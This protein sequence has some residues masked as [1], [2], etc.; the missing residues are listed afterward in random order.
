M[1]PRF[2]TAW[3]DSVYASSS[4]VDVVSNY[5]QLQKKGRRHW[6]LCPFH[7]EKTPSFTVN[8][9]MNLYY[10]FGCK[11]SGNIVQFVMEME[12][13]TYQEALVSLAKQ[14]NLPPPPAMEDDP[15][16]DARRNL[17]ERLIEATKEAALYYHD[18]LWLPEN[19]AALTYLH[20][21][22]LDDAVIRR[23]G[24]G[25]SP[26]DW[27]SL[28]NHLQTK[29]FTLEELQ[30]A[31]LVTV[32]ENSRYDTFR[33]RVMFPI[34]NRY[35]QTIG[36]GA[37]AMGSAQPKY[38]N[39]SES[40]IFNK[41]F[42]VYG[43]NQLK[44]LR[45]PQ[46]LILVEGYLDVITLSQAGISNVIAT[47]GTALTTEQVRLVKNYAP[48]VWV[49]YDGDEP[50]QTA[51]LRALDVLHQEGVP[52]CVICFPEGQDPDDFV[53]RNGAEG[54]WA[55]KPVQSMAFRLS[56]LETQHDLGNDDGKREF[57][58]QACQ[59]L[60]IIKE[61]VEIDYYLGRIT[62][63]TGIAKEVLL[64]QMNRDR[65]LKGDVLHES[66]SNRKKPRDS[67]QIDQSEFT[68]V[69]LLATGKLPNK[70]VIANEFEDERLR[71]IVISLLDGKSPVNIMEEA[72]DEQTRH[73]AGELFNRLPELDKADTLTAAEDCLRKIRSARLNARI[74][75]LSDEIKSQELGQKALTLELIKELKSELNRQTNHLAQ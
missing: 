34:I 48:E 24:L 71:N 35:G 7:N 30:Q 50:G 61:P 72:Q 17:R 53:R 39:T 67:S 38:L 68:L 70:L 12:K 4:I 14:F 6:G 58:R 29:E 23:F 63:K 52:S 56:R 36:F 75:Q 31:A 33:G 26:D 65:S 49:A 37:R 20:E 40:L 18:Q 64:Q 32:K 25:A 51:T 44:R 55:L 22:G 74:N 21:R 3:V 47:L 69:A 16:E 11:A 54:F 73:M 1:A 10:C 9:E 57:A 2:P 8:S 43:I 46:Q 66:S 42:N 13:F 60:Q 19:S 5:L 41:R 15:L 59:T 27:D 45:N 62:L 28:L